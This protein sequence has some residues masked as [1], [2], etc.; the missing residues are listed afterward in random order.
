MKNFK[1][2]LNDGEL[3]LGTLISI[4]APEVA[5]I[6]SQAGF[7]WLFI[8]AEHAP[9]S[10]GDIQHLIQAA[11][12]LPCL[13]R[14]HSL[15]EIAIKKVLDSG[16]EG[17]IVPQ[18]NSAAEA[19]LAV[20][21]AKYPPQG[22]RGVGIARAQGYGLAFQDYI[23]RANDEVV[24]IVQAEHARAVENIEAIAATPGVDG[25]FIGPYDLSASLG[26]MGRLEDPSVREA[27]Q[28][29][30][31]ACRAAG[32]RLG[33]FCTSA[34]AALPYVEKGFTLITTGTD[35]LLLG[36]GGRDML[37]KIKAR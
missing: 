3:L 6:L 19:A 13:V 21:Y 30:G 14:V 12:P 37:A 25:I 33:V 35:T 11:A 28:G 23:E 20:A 9:L 22:Q 2:Q 31:Q 8:D 27:I 18:V 17:I 16:A 7:D 26:K 5:E 4:A 29:I 32:T 1:Q 15:D 34:E 24:V 36:L 10:A